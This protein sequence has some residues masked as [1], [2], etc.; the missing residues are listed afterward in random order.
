M[1][2]PITIQASPTAFQFVYM[3]LAINKTDRHGPS[4][5][6]RCELLAKKP[7]NVAY[8][9]VHPAVKTFTNYS[10]TLLQDEAFTEVL[11]VGMPCRL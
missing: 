5:E 9:P 11:K 8:F 3:A 6:A 4:S 7:G 10:Y 2:A 1:K